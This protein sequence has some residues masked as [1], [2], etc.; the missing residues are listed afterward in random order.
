MCG[1]RVRRRLALDGLNW[2]AGLSPAALL[3]SLV[4]PGAG[5]YL[6]AP[7]YWGR[8]ALALSGVLIFII[9]A[10]LGFP[11]AAY[12]FGLLLSL[13]ACGL[14]FVLN[15]LLVGAA[16]RIRL[17]LAGGILFALLCLVYVPGRDFVQGH[18]FLPLQI[19]GRVVIIT[20]AYSTTGIRRGDQVAFSFGSHVEH[21]LV[22]QGGFG[23]GPVLGMPGDHVRFSASDFEVNGVARPRLAHMP[24]EGE[25]VVP[26][27]HW[28]VWPEVGISGHGQVP[29]SQIDEALLA[30][31][32][33]S[34]D[35]FVG[36]PAHRWLWRKQF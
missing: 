18:W 24:A 22:I 10:W 5:F 2:P 19:K 35:Q 27:K 16:F 14:L 7:R 8:L 1:A 17:L 9:I 21:Q 34:Q 11:G 13:H 29:T 6:R 28:F 4:V 26:E 3:V 36:R 15:P 23:L 25:F 12:A 20:R 31:S 33:I 30:M 32:T